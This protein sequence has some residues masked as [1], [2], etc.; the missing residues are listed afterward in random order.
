MLPRASYF[1]PGIE[2]HAP[3]ARIGIN[4]SLPPACGEGLGGTGSRGARLSSTSY[5]VR[6]SENRAWIELLSASIWRNFSA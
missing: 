2:K 5:R 4:G 6:M 3:S 1:H